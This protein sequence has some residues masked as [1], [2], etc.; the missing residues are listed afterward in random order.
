MKSLF[1]IMILVML[2]IVI[3]FPVNAQEELNNINLAIAS[4]GKFEGLLANDIQGFVQDEAGYLYLATNQGVWKYNGS[5]FYPVLTT[6]QGLASNNILSLFQDSADNLWVG[7]GKGLQKVS[8]GQ[9]VATFSPDTPIWTPPIEDRAGNIWYTDLATSSLVKIIGDRVDYTLG[10]AEGIK[11]P[12]V[13]FND[14]QNRVW[15]GTDDGLIHIE[16]KQI[17]LQVTENEG[18][19]KNGIHLLFEDQMG[20]I[21]VTDIDGRLSRVKDGQA[22]VM[23]DPVAGYFETVL[24]DTMGTIWLGSSNGLIRYRPGESPQHFTTDQGLTDNNVLSLFEDREGNI[25]IG[26]VNGV[27][28]ITKTPLMQSFSGPK[29]YAQLVDHTGTIWLG[30]AMGLYQL[31]ND[32]LSKVY[33]V[34]NGLASDNIKALVEDDQNRLWVGTTAG[35]TVIDQGTVK[36]T[37]TSE[38]GLP[39]D[40]VWSLLY[41]SQ[42]RIW[43]G[44]DRGIA[45]L[46]ND[47]VSQTFSGTADSTVETRIEALV[48][49]KNG[50]I[51]VGA[52]GYGLTLL[53][54]DGTFIRRYDEADGFIGS[55][56]R[57]LAADTQ[58][59]VW[60]P[61][62]DGAVHHLVNEEI[63]ASYSAN[64]ETILDIPR[65]VVISSNGTAWIGLDSFGLSSIVSNG[66][67][68]NYSYADGLI[69]S[70]VYSLNKD[71]NGNILIGTGTGLVRFNT[72]PFILDLQLDAVT[73]P[74]IDEQGQAYEIPLTPQGDGSYHIN[75]NQQSIRFRY[76]SLDYRVE[77]K[78]FQ[79]KLEG[80]DQF[81]QNM[82]PQ[83]ERTYM[84]LPPGNYT[85]KVRVEN[86][87]GTWNA[88][89]IAVNLSVLPPWWETAWFRGLL[90]VSFV[91][92]MIVGMRWR[93]QTIEKHNRL[94]E[95][96]VTERTKALTEKSEQL[97][98]SN[99]ALAETN[100]ALALS[101]IALAETKQKAEVASEAKSAFLANM[102]HELRSPLN[103]ILGFTQVMRRSSL[104]RD[105]MEHLDIISRS[106]EHLLTLIN[107]VL[108]LSKIEAGRTTLNQ[109]DFALYHLLEE[110]EHMFSLKADSNG[111]QLTF[112]QA[113]N[114][115]RYIRTDEL[116]LRQVLINLINNA[117]K[118]TKDGGVTVRITRLKTTNLNKALLQFEVEDSGPGIT[119]E[120]L[121]SLFEAFV[122][123]E[124][125]KQSKEGTG[126]GLPISRKFVQL[127]GG[128]MKVISPVFQDREN[129]GTN[130]QFTI[131]TDILSSI[132]DLSVNQQTK[133][134]V[135]L[136]PNQ[137]HYRI[138]VVDDNWVNRY[139]LLKL[140]EPLGF[141]LKEATNGQ[142]AVDIWSTWQPHL[143]WMDMRM[144]V[145]DGYEATEQIKQHLKGQATAVIAL[146]AS[147]LEEEK[148]I[149]LSAGCDGIIRK[150][151]Q[152][153]EI[154]ETMHQHIGVQYLYETIDSAKFHKSEQTDY[155]P[156][157][158]QLVRLSPD[159]LTQLH[160]AATE[161]NLSAMNEVLQVIQTHNVDLAEQLNTLADDF[162]YETI[163]ELTQ[164]VQGLPHG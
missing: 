96:Q 67:L 54:A 6:R 68:K 82:G 117:L 62:A 110:V 99:N 123:T 133:R 162:D 97:A 141:E 57:G 155:K 148:A 17:A 3:I 8:Q 53:D 94:L 89:E 98:E 65:A 2:L 85:F 79:T 64:E 56:V 100:E 88:E 7:T 69:N 157:Q 90:L 75:Y 93:V 60:A 134:V 95:T 129:K 92:V 87:D 26:T 102:S 14:S 58:G 125:G 142:E 150:P 105:N 72:T 149:V 103:A 73:L 30:S 84:N 43:I 91:S 29:V 131:Q 140:L 55:R 78:Q 71:Q 76:A 47:I 138:L 77:M 20:Y 66:F 1:R 24:V 143:I 119:P 21:W 70:T 5:Q 120:E 151:F 74:Q 41:D 130:F 16:D 27:N 116:K 126:L 19:Q 108:D 139:L 127:M 37:Y 135:A 153:H 28:K 52:R 12:Y 159:I 11:G 122:Q 144:P 124:T 63:I 50:R 128:D 35:L 51:F 115:P 10:E 136:Q 22:E 45:L 154:F 113:D 164:H 161:N 18:L 34:E 147:V 44:T 13:I 40:T 61:A 33:T 121:D 9:V 132:E 106:G 48:E 46:E 39:A 81:W 137:P 160:L 111:L 49:G 146:T 32:Q 31:A 152:E 156:L 4:Y 25:W 15:V 107:Q 80:Y 83:S 158:L 38:D 86:F 59:N 101:N 112:H 42:G 163:A 36:Q 109:T 114:I 118:F 104:S 145:M 23:L